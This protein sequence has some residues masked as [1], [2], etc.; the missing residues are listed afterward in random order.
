MTSERVVSVELV[1]RGDIVRVV[2]GAKVPVDGEVV[3]GDSRWGGRGRSSRKRN[4]R[5]ISGK[6]I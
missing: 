2:P 5:S 1:H 6:K 4:R 3:Q